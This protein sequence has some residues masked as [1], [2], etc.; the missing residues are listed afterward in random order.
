VHSIPVQSSTEFLKSVKDMI[1][2]TV[3]IVSLSKGIHSE[4]LKFMNDV[5]ADALGRKQPM[6]FLSGPSFARELMED[7]PTGLVLASEDE[8]LVQ[9]LQS[10]LASGRL[11]VYTSTDVIGVE[12]GGALKNIY[13][14]AAGMAEGMG[15]KLN[16]A[17]LLVTRGC[18]EMRK[19]ATT[20]GAKPQTLSGLSGIGDLMLTCFGPASRN[21]SVGV[22][23]GKGEKLA[24]ILASMP[25]VAEG[26][27]TA[28]A[29]AKLLVKLKLDLPLS[30]AVAD[31]LAGK[32]TP[33]QRLG[34]LMTLPLMPED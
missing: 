6:A 24:D 16:T 14:I 22:R 21:R 31:I 27:P 23:L 2:E 1:P 25:E 4:T 19:L 28:A 17:A 29:A 13:A 10:M 11:R 18:S 8:K 33:Q 5:I 7:Q 12:V 26:V 34:Y 32:F 15:F 20:L 30:Q 3:P 9:D